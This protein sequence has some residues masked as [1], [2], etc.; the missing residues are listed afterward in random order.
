MIGV[1]SVPVSL[2]D[3]LRRLVAVERVPPRVHHDHGEALVRDG[4]QRGRLRFGARD[5]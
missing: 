4:A 5:P 1:S 3:P 2:P